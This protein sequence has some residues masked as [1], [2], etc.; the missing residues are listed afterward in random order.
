MADLTSPQGPAGYSCKPPAKVTVDDFVYSGL[1]V[2]GNTSNSIKASINTAFAD[3]FTGLNGLGLSM[4]WAAGAISMHSH[5]GSSETLLIA[6][7]SVTAAFISSDN[8]VFLKKLKEGDI[9]VFPQGLLHFEV[10]TGQKPALI[11]VS[12][13]SSNP[14]LQIL[15]YGLF[16]S[17]L[18]S[19]LIEK[20]TFLD[21]GEVNRLKGLLGG[22]G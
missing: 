11:W 20:T 8:T 13:S 10:N 5:P 15:S 14:G 7:G 21:D 22:S 17:N 16:G 18:P 9:M 1:A 6:K 3:K 12:F 19:E 2:A 4:A